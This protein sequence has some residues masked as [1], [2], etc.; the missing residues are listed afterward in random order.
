MAAIPKSEMPG[1]S[2][3][4]VLDEKP[5]SMSAQ[6]ETEPE[7]ERV[8]VDRVALESLKGTTAELSERLDTAMA[9]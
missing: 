9:N 4:P 2:S 6:P 1:A 8:E 3:I 7:P 5:A